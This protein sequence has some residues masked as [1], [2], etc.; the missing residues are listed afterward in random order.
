M[1]RILLIDDDPQFCASFKEGAPL[2]VIVDTFVDPRAAL[3]H[4]LTRPAYDLVV[5]DYWLPRRNGE[6]IV[7]DI[8]LQNPRQNIILISG[9]FSSVRVPEAF[10]VRMLAKPF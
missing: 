5:V 10:G 1:Y 7:F 3:E 8:K 2:G 9:D 4:Y 6:G